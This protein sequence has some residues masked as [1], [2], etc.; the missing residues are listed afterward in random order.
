MV[1]TTTAFHLFKISSKKTAQ[2][3]LRPTQSR[4]PG[5]KEAD[6]DPGIIRCRQC[7]GQITHCS[8]RTTAGGQHTHTFVNPHGIVFEIG[9]FTFAN[10][11]DP[12]GPASTEFTWFEDFSWQI[13]VCGFCRTHLGWWFS[14]NY[15]DSFYGLIMDRLLL[16]ENYR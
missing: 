13:V 6:D 10:G 16:P 12:V 5:A 8:A 1:S 9:C 15:A 11:C 14:S 7:R 4:H 2:A 3:R